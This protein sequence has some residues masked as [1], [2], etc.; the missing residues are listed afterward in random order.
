MRKSFF[1]RVLHFPL[2]VLLLATLWPATARSEEIWILVGNSRTDTLWYI[3]SGNVNCPSSEVVSVWVKSVPDKTAP[4]AMQW[5]E[6]TD[7]TLKRIQAKYFG[8]YEHTEGLWELDCPRGMFRILYFSAFGANGETVSS[9]L[10]PD[11]RWTPLVPGSVGETLKE[12]VC[13]A[14]E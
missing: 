11:S 9:S 2:P 7:K 4:G 6:S 14:Q 3:D 13:P 10:T 1:D 5:E 8:D 12:A